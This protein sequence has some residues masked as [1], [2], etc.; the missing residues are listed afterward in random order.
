MKRLLKY[1]Q[2][3]DLNPKNAAANF[4]LGATYQAKGDLDAAI[5]AYNT[6]LTY[7]ADNDQYKKALASA[8]DQKAKPIIDQAVEEHKN[9]NYAKAD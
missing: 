4:D 5:D 7:D 9:K 8:L 1:K 3:L 6:A 2:L